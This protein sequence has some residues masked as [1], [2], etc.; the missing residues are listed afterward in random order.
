VGFDDEDE[1]EVD[2][3]AVE[4]LEGV[5]VV[6]AEEAGYVAMG[7]GDGAGGPGG[8]GD[9]LLQGLNL[10][11]PLRDLLTALGGAGVPSLAASV[12]DEVDEEAQAQ[13]LR[14]SLE[15]EGLSEALV[16]LRRVTK[17]TKG[18]NILAF[19]AVV[20]IGDRKGKVGMGVGKGKEVV[21]ATAKAVQDAKGNMKNI[22]VTKSKSIPHKIVGKS[23]AS[24]VVLRPA[25]EG[26]G[27]LAGG[28]TR[29]VLELAG[30]QNILTKQ[31]GSNSLLN[32]ARATLDGLSR[33]QSAA[34][35]AEE[36][37]IKIRQLYGIGGDISANVHS[38][39]N[40]SLGEAEFESELAK[41]DAKCR[42]KI[43]ADVAWLQ[44]NGKPI[45][46]TMSRRVKTAA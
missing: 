6:S 9:D 29:T 33:L 2:A 35:V 21:V 43:L 38:V 20:V 14:R 23:T 7:A 36:R 44:K 46:P 4:G 3:G 22:P 26:T 8:E 16:E 27:V 41:L 12:G 15:A 37:G 10:E 40:T 13:A 42:D 5:E 39:E 24:R 30:V 31:L 1:G 18:G 45:Q 25:A 28:A 11:M 32:N 34:D 19:R 17:V